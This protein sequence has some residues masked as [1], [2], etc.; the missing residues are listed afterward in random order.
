MKER[1]TLAVPRRNNSCVYCIVELVLTDL[2]FFDAS[3]HAFEKTGG[4]VVV[5]W[6]KTLLGTNG[7]FGGFWYS[8]VYLLGIR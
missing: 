8:S 6:C 7:N 2:S 4:H 3:Q 1:C 5:I